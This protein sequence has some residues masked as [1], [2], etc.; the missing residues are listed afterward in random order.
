MAERAD[1]ISSA[2]MQ[3]RDLNGAHS[4]DLK[5]AQW[6]RFRRTDMEMDEEIGERRGMLS[7]SSEF[8]F[9]IRFVFGVIAG[10]HLLSRP[11]HPRRQFHRRAAMRHLPPLLPLLS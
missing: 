1:Q 4:P 10:V 9:S 8:S 11:C 6:K 7:R 5:T 2:Q 3:V